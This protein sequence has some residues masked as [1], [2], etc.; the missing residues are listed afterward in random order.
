MRE[1]ITT[2]TRAIIKIIK[3][4]VKGIYKYILKKDY[5]SRL[6]ANSKTS[7]SFP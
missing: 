5:F 7:S 1:T 2:Q 4:Q 6:S 3:I